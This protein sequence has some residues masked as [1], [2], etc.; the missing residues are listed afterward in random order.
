MSLR[1]EIA[2]FNSGGSGVEFKWAQQVLGFEQWAW[3]PIFL[4]SLHTQTISLGTQGALTTF[5][6]SS[7]SCLDRS[8]LFFFY[9]FLSSSSAGPVSSFLYFSLF[10]SF[11]SFQFSSSLLVLQKRARAGKLDRC[12]RTEQ[13]RAGAALASQLAAAT[14]GNAGRDGVDG[15]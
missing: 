1:R 12:W 7:L 10:L 14:R 8:A 5:D 9:Y 13:L 15:W 3:R 6:R 2:H 4:S 11:I